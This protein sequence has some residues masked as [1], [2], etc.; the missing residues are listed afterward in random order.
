MSKIF[1]ILGFC[2]FAGILL[3]AAP[4][5]TEPTA[6]TLGRQ[7]TSLMDQKK[8]S[9]AEA[10]LNR[11]LSLDPSNVMNLY[12]MA[13]VLSLQ[14]KKDQAMEYLARSA[15][16]GLTDFD[17]ILEDKDFETIRDYPPFKDFI[18]KKQEYQDKSASKVL[19]YFKKEFGEGYLYELD[20][21]DK[22]VFVVDSDPK[23]LE[24]LKLAILRQTASLNEQIFERKPDYYIAVLLPTPSDF[25]TIVPQPGANGIYDPDRHTLVCL[26]M[27][28]VLT[29]EF[30]HA[31]HHA[32]REGQI[33]P[34]WFCEGLASMYEAGRFENDKLIPADNY[35]LSAVQDA[36]RRNALIP[37]SRLLTMDQ[38]TFVDNATLAYGESS[39]F[40][41]YLHE[42][43]LLKPFYQQLKKD[44]ATDPTG[45]K[46]LQKTTG[47]TL[48]QLE[49]DWKAW[50]LK[51]TPPP[52]SA[53][54]NSA[55]IGIGFVQLNDGLQVQSVGASTPAAKAGVKAGDVLVG[56]NNDEVRDQQSIYP[57]LAIHEPGDEVLLK[58]RRG[59]KYVE[60]P[61]KL[62]KRSELK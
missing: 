21:K 39:S 8:H 38:K 16:A 20:S 41:L 6:T 56:I 54:P 59:E 29:H 34:Q 42:Q 58:L 44:V 40:L 37:F 49:S 55:V 46:T 3:G 43:G 25:R 1:K 35:R 62:I 9:E 23:T 52:S 45:V 30:T 19:D 33:H 27:G 48:A 5:A 10:L 32:D 4:A 36:G 24:A 28:Q 60:I 7:A 17:S 22:F 18:A 11:A 31:L 47:R 13:C 50:M 14:G 53:G 15:E 61:V 51:R 2:L 26:K 57:L 12:N